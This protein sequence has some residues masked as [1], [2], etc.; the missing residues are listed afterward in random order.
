MSRIFWQSFFDTFSGAALFG[1]L[2]MPGQPDEFI[3]SRPLEEFLRSDE[4]LP[5]QAWLQARRQQPS[6]NE[7]ADK[8]YIKS[9]LSK[10]FGD[11]LGDAPR[12]AKGGLASLLDAKDKFARSKAEFAR[13]LDEAL[14]REYEAQKKHA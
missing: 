10:L 6:W 4:F 3:D 2:P 7:H 14:Q 9:E 8:L 5:M 12:E 13:V 1:P 11:L